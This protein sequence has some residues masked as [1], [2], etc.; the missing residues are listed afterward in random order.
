[1]KDIKK[2]DFVSWDSSGGRAMGQVVKVVMDGKVD[3]IPAKVNGTKDDPA[4]KIRLYKKEDGEWVATDTYVGHKLDS[5]RKIKPIKKSSSR[6]KR[7]S[8]TID[9]IDLEIVEQEENNTYY[10]SPSDIK[11]QEGD[12]ADNVICKTI[13]LSI[14]EYQRFL[15]QQDGALILDIDGKKLINFETKKD[16]EKALDEFIESYNMQFERKKHEIGFEKEGLEKEAKEKTTNFPTKGDN[17]KITLKNSQFPQFDWEYAAKIKEEYPEIWKKGGNIRGNE[18]YNHWTKARA[19]KFSPAT[20]DWIKERE[21][22]MARHEGDFRL[23]GVVAV[24][25][26]GGVCKKGMSYMKKLINE[27]K[28][29]INERK[30][31]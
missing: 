31:K 13:N 19:G 5:I 28:K 17:Q 30:N 3:G 27:E 6:L 10:I 21:A 26:W 22:W 15:G 18:A 23:A 8:S 24:M 25:K 11:I 2:G 20:L 29:K 4:A 16:A 12:T 1:M 14:Q 7:V 9:I